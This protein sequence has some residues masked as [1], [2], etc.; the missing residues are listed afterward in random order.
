M[1]FTHQA[2][3]DSRAF[4]YIRNF[5]THVARMTGLAPGAV[6]RYQ[7]GDPDATVGGWSDTFTFKAQDDPRAQ[8]YP[9]RH[10]IVGDMGAG[11]AYTLCRNCTCD[12][13]CDRQNCTAR[14][15]G[16]VM[17]VDAGPGVRVDMMLHVG[18]FAY[19]L[20]LSLIHI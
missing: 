19:N 2:T 10:I 15:A 8:T 12:E 3:G 20:G 7:V 9:R 16:L 18:D 6:Y 1:N 17:E 5:T 13:Q 14:D 11:C 4:Y